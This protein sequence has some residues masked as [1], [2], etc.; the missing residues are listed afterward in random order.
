MGMAAVG[1]GLSSTAVASSMLRLQEIAVAMR[2][3]PAAD[4]P[5]FCSAVVL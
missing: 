3:A 5:R 1:S 2:V 4:Q